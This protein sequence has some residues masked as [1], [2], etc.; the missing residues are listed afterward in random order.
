MDTADKRHTQIGIL[1]PEDVE[2]RPRNPDTVPSP[3][4]PYITKPGKAG[5]LHKKGFV[6]GQDTV[7]SA[8]RVLS[9]RPR[10]D[11]ILETTWGSPWEQYRRSFK[12]D[13]GGLVHLARRKTRPYGCVLIRE[14]PV[15]KAEETLYWFRR[16]RHSNITTALEVFVTDDFL[17][18][19]LEEMAINLARIVKCPAYPDEDQLSCILGQVRFLLP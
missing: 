14:F 2:F 9:R 7:E 1:M 5:K 17:H 11:R 18:V 15:A 3:T 4:S 12:F 16:I 6:S 13:L 8:R 19:V 10:S